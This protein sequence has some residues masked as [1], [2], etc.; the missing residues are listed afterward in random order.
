MSLEGLGT[1][2][3]LILDPVNSSHQMLIKKMEDNT[4]PLT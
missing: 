1:L 2:F 4:W 3:G